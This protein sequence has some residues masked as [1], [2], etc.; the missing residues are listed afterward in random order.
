MVHAGTVGLAVTNALNLNSELIS[1]IW[2]IQIS[3]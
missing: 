3:I 1:I 2:N